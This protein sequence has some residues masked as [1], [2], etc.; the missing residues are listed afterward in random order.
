MEDNAP[1]PRYTEIFVNILAIEEF[2]HQ[3]GQG[4][5]HTL[6]ENDIVPIRLLNLFKQGP[7]HRPI[8]IVNVYIIFILRLLRLPN[9]SNKLVGDSIS[10]HC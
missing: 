1:F 10:R 3:F 2:V 6:I 8:S 9:C 5:L 7:A 4:L